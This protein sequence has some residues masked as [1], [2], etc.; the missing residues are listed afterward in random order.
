MLEDA[1]TYRKLTREDFRA[2]VLPPDRIMHESSINAYTCAQIRPTQDSKYTV[3]RTQ[4][5]GTV[6]YIGSIQNIGFEAI[7]IPACSWWNP[8]LPAFARRYVLQHE[9]IHFAIAE[10]AARQLTAQTRQSALTFMA[11]QPTYGGAIEE[12]NDKVKSWIREASE[13]SLAM[14]TAF[15][16]DTSLFHSP[17]WQRWWKK[18]IDAKL[19]ELDPAASAVTDNASNAKKKKDP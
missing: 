18:E 16:E 4:Y 2:T 5:N 10:L 1:F 17:K 3:N 14:H 15:D 19:A 6:F 11:I 13:G 12:V 7:M 9:Q 8:E